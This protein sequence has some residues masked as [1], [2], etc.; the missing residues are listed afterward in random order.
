MRFVKILSP[1]AVFMLIGA[2]AYFALE[3]IYSIAKGGG[4]GT[5]LGYATYALLTGDAVGAETDEPLDPSGRALTDI[6]EIEV[7]LDKMKA[8]GI[9]LGNTPYDELQTPKS[10]TQAAIK[11]CR[12]HKPNLRKVQVH[13]VT[14]LF[15]PF[16][17]IMA[18]WD[19]E[20][21]LDPEVEAFIERYRFSKRAV[22]NTNKFGDRIT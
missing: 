2:I 16:K 4:P 10:S 20:R 17:P 15:H 19:D 5:S 11:G 12:R 8:D 13:L 18:F 22:M 3:G 21:Q 6:S 9:G 14:R 1:V 7:L